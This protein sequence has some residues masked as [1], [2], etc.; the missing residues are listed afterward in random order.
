[1][2]GLCFLLL[3]NFAFCKVDVLFTIK[4]DNDLKF[5]TVEFKDTLLNDTSIVDATN[6]WFVN[7]TDFLCVNG[8]CVEEVFEFPK[9]LSLSTTATPTTTPK[10]TP[11]PTPT[12]TPTSTTPI[13]KTN[14]KEPP[15]VTIVLIGVVIALALIILFFV[16]G[17]KGGVARVAR[18]L[19]SAIQEPYVLNIAIDWPPKPP[20]QIKMGCDLL[21]GRGHQA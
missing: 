12:P 5:D 10:T 11:T 20:P 18:P 6:L 13:I 1:M 16:Q 17:R 7:V 21:Q 15:A 19:N 3:F 2:R 8:S 4:R 9:E 14:T